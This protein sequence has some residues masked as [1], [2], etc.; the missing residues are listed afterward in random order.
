MKKDIRN[1]ENMPP[2]IKFIYS[3]I[4]SLMTFINGNYNQLKIAEFYRIINKIQL[5]SS[6]RIDLMSIIIEKEM[7]FDQISI[8]IDLDE[9]LDDQEKNIF[10]FS[11]IKD[12]IIIMKSDYIETEDEKKLLKNI[13]NHFNISNEQLSF[14]YE[15]YELDRCFFD[16]NISDSK[17]K[18]TTQKIVST[19]TALGIPLTVI[20]C[21]GNFKGLGFLGAISGLRTLGMKRKT[22][23]YSLI[24]GVSTSIALGI[25]TYKSIEY[26]LHIRKDE[27]TKLAHLMKEN[28]EVLH[29]TTKHSLYNDIEYFSHRTIDVEYENEKELDN[30]LRLIN[31]LKSAVATL[32]NTEAVI[33]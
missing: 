29:E 1:L 10:R 13:Q 6:N 25:V 14:F 28:M 4:L 2:N 11:L 24:L 23:K 15:E 7:D 21:S 27:K 20:Y 9:D 33:V 3:K 19:A 18:K 32:E 30:S 22:G 31:I 26:I 8:Q 5:P 17:L 12:L 16:N